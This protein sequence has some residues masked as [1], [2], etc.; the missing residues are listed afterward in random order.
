[1]SFTLRFSTIF[2]ALAL[3]SVIFVASSNFF[4]Y[5]GVKAYWFRLCVSLALIFFLGWVGFQ[6][7]NEEI[8]RLFK[9]TFSSPLV[10]ATTIFAVI[11]VLASVFAY[12]PLAAFW[13]NLERGEGGFQMIYYYL[14]FLLLVLTGRDEKT[15]LLFLWTTLIAAVLVIGYGVSS[16]VGIINSG[17]STAGGI[18]GQRFAG[19][20]GNPAYLG[21]YMLFSL[22]FA[23]FLI[24]GKGVKFGERLALISL[25]IL[26]FAFFLFAQT[27]GAFLGLIVS[28]VV[29]LLFYAFKNSVH[30]RSLIITALILTLLFSTLI[31]FR[32]SPAI[33]NMPVIGRLL[34][35]SVFDRSVQSRLW[36]WQTAY[37]GWKERPILGWGP[38]NFTKVFNNRFDIRHFVPD[39][40]SDTWYDRAHSVFFDYLVETGILGLLSYLGIFVVFYWQFFKQ[41]I[42]SA[43]FFAFPV[44]Y[45][46]QGIVLFE[47]LP[48]YLPFFF[49]LAFSVYR[50]QFA[51]GG[52][53]ND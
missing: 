21:S 37:E 31:Y 13:S 44:A 35:V 17:M 34:R 29:F 10:L 45:L 32:E 42:Q 40:T 48:I 7:S 43:L 12:D 4:P 15:W 28:V 3:L 5:I 25:S 23:G 18:F 36:V 52:V 51:V 2:L 39:E 53:Q 49:F 41:K 8:R 16:F 24:S 20:L 30:R 14:F 38:E 1:M 27:R 9:Q 50:F 26:F 33:K 46:I 22:F 19:S 47:I 6:S 11:F